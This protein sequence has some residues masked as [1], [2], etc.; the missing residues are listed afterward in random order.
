M[1]SNI[2]RV[3]R[4]AAG[5]DLLDE[6]LRSGGDFCRRDDLTICTLWE[7]CPE[8]YASAANGY[9][10][11]IPANHQVSRCSRRLRR[12]KRTLRVMD[13]RC[14]TGSAS[15]AFE[16]RI[17]S[18]SLLDVCIAVRN[19]ANAELRNKVHARKAMLSGSKWGVEARSTGFVDKSGVRPTERLDN[20]PSGRGL[21]VKLDGCDSARFRAIEHEQV[22]PLETDP[23]LATPFF[24]PKIR[25]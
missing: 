9:R 8:A 18:V 10:H 24:G 14:L 22:R 23:S 25:K 7:F 15:S 16:R 1:C 17:V 19:T 4:S 11:W 12:I 13:R 2:V 6:R 5:P 3:L 20:Q 21:A